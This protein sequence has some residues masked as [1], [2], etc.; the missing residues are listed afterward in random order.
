M[1]LILGLLLRSNSRSNLW[2]VGLFSTMYVGFLV[3]VSLRPLLTTPLITPVCFLLPCGFAA[4]DFF[5]CSV[6]GS[7]CVVL[8]C[9]CPDCRAETSMQHLFVTCSVLLLNIFVWLKARPLVGIATHKIKSNT[10][11]LLPADMHFFLFV[12]H[13]RTHQSRR[14]DTITHSS[15]RHR[16]QFAAVVLKLFVFYLKQDACK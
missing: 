13:R 4:A 15:R 10:S 7:S 8:V 14:P 9:M 16:T 6:T 11:D 1:F 12:L 2:R 3:G 5:A